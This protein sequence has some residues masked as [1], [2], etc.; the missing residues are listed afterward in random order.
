MSCICV[1]VQSVCVGVFMCNTT[2]SVCGIVCVCVGIIYS[3][4]ARVKGKIALSVFHFDISCVMLR[5]YS[6]SSKSDSVLLNFAYYL[7]SCMLLFFV[8]FVFSPVDG[9]NLGFVLSVTQN[10]Q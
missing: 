10:N 1:I 5:L 9:L 3:F 2:Q 7:F 6:A 4:G 8:L